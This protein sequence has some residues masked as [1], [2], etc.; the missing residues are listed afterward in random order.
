MVEGKN[1]SEVAGPSLTTPFLFAKLRSLQLADTARERRVSI[2]PCPRGM[3]RSAA[4]M[5]ILTQSLCSRHS[6]YES[7]LMSSSLSQLA[8]F[9][10]RPI[11]KKR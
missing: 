6:V 1:N 4:S 5:A 2:N 9:Y 8:R 11:E 3:R 7:S 10:A